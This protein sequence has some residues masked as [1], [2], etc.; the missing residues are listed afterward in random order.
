[1]NTGIIIIGLALVMLS[2]GLIVSPSSAAHPLVFGDPDC[3]GANLTEE[4]SS[5]V[6]GPGVVGMDDASWLAGS[7]NG[8]Q[9]S[10]FCSGCRVMYGIPQDATH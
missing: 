3:G 4:H 1:M 10:A 6:A 9:L 5:D 7:T 2:C 8:A